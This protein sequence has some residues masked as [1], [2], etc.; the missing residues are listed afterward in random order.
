MNIFM[1][2]LF[3]CLFLSEWDLDFL[4]RIV[5]LA[6]EAM[7]IIAA[8]IV[9]VNFVRNKA[10]AIQAKY[11]FFFMFTL[12]L[13]IVGITINMVQP[14]AIINGTRN[15][16]KYLPVFLLPAVYAFS[17]KEI[18]KQLKFLF[19]LVLAQIP[20]AVYQRVY[21]YTQESADFI[22][23]TLGN[24]KVLSGILLWTIAILFALYLKQKISAKILMIIVL[25]LLIPIVLNETAASLFLFPLAF[26]TP[27]LFANLGHARL[28]YFIVTSVVSSFFLTLLVVGYDYTY[29][30]RWGSGGIVTLV[31]EG[32]VL[33]YETETD[34]NEYGSLAVGRITAINL[35]FE[36]L[37]NLDPT[38]LMVGV[39]IGNASDSIIEDFT[40]EYYEEYSD[41]GITKHSFSNI[42]WSFGLIGVVLFYIF[43]LMVFK[44]AQILSSSSGIS[45]V[46]A[47]GSLGI[48]A[49]FL[50]QSIYIN[51]F[52][53]NIFGALFAYM[54]GYLAS[55]RIW[56]NYN[57]IKH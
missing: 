51:I 28:K 54:S 15:F 55:Y 27:L 25:L 12:L 2:F 23:G 34:R 5:K 36:K 6:P 1:Y 44:D 32:K 22:A 14:G 3:I 46:I 38:K 19:L 18:A 8:A 33:D 47:V 9:L 48:L 16:L 41:Y 26:I 57:I 13:I 24:A 52:I 7:F 50:L 30:E 39:G 20:L 37:W 29:S 11:L 43:C 21:V 56:I 31:T 35:A 45:G 10:I 40:G 17:D 4:P 49:I 53:D 42:M